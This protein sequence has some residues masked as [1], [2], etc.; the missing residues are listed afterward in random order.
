MRESSTLI[1]FES[2]DEGDLN[3]YPFA[4]NDEEELNPYLT[5][6]LLGIALRRLKSTFST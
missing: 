4:S 3:P 2:N 6:S 1:N 5:T